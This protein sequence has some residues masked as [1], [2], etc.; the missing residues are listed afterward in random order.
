MSL[1]HSIN[2]KKMQDVLIQKSSPR[3]RDQLYRS[4]KGGR[5]VSSAGGAKRG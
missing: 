5:E 3:S 2:F 4:L 1:N